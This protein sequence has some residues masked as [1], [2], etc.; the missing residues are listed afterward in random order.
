[1]YYHLKFSIRILLVDRS[2]VE[3]WFNGTFPL[4]SFH[5]QDNLDHLF[6]WFEKIPT[7]LILCFSIFLSLVLYFWGSWDDIEIFSIKMD[8]DV[9]RK[10]ELSIIVTLL[11]PFFK[12]KIIFKLLMIQIV[13]IVSWAMNHIRIFMI[14][15]F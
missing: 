10:G 12:D 9:A 4:N 11:Y 1:M 6:H 7:T 15:M 5:R 8:H 14:M 13:L 2:L 3:L